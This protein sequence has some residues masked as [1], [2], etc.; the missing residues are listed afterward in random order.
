MLEA[1]LKF[2]APDKD[3]CTPIPFCAKRKEKNQ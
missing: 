3:Y 2:A 1:E